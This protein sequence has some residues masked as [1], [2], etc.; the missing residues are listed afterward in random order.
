MDQKE[1]YHLL[2]GLVGPRYEDY[3]PE[4]LRQIAVQ[5]MATMRGELKS[6]ETLFAAAYPETCRFHL[7]EKIS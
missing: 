7:I 2:C 6:L 1:A 3:T 5:R 4:E